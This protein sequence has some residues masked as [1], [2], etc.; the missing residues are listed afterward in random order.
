MHIIRDTL[1]LTIGG[2]CTPWAGIN[3]VSERQSFVAP[4]FRRSLS[5]MDTVAHVKKLLVL[6]LVLGACT[7]ASEITTTGAATVEPVDDAGS[8]SS[9]FAGPPAVPDGPLDPAIDNEIG[10]LIISVAQ[11]RFDS[12]AL[13]EIGSGND[14]RVAWLLADLLRFYQGGGTG[15]HISRVFRDLTG[16]TLDTSTSPA[17]VDAFNHLIAW[18]LPAWEGYGI[19]KGELYTILEPAWQPFFDDNVSIDWRWITWGGVLIDDRPL[20]D[21]NP[22]ERGCIPALD[23]PPTVPGDEVTWLADSDIVFGV[24]HNGDALAMPRNQMEVHE[25]LNLSVGGARLGIPYCTLCGSAQTYLT[26]S[27]PDGFETAVLRTSGLLSRSNK[28]MY[29]LVTGS[30]FNTFTGEALSGPLGREGVVLDQVTVVASTWGEWLAEHPDTRIIAQDGG[31]GRIYE[32]NPL[33]DRDADGPIFPVG[34][35]DPRLDVHA[36]VVGVVAGDGT[37]IAFPVVSATNALDMGDS[38]ALNGYEVI[39]DGGGL[40]V[41]GPDGEVVAHESFWFAWSQFHPE[42]LL[43]VDA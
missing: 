26:E 15:S 37:P 19:R 21:P 42:T 27:V 38:V 36:R 16:V 41:V 6:C 2:E 29:D 28:V 34:P 23:D 14:A 20:G 8:Q 33:G 40:R 35:V 22:C 12:D 13:N 24:V 18:D 32:P 9:E 7:P 3:Q 17:F 39:A 11:E 1:R 30:V 31:L 43:W 4:V 10:G 5:S 25:M